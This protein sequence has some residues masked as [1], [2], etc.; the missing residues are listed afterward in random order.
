MAVSSDTVIRFVGDL[1][2]KEA[3]TRFARLRRVPSTY[4]WRCLD[5]LQTIARAR[6]DRLFNDI[7]ERAPVHLGLVPP[8]AK[9]QSSELARFY[10]EV[11]QTPSPHISSRL[12]RGMVASMRTDGPQ[13]FFSNL[14]QEMTNKADSIRPTTAAK[15]R[16]D[17]KREF[18]EHFG[19]STLNTG[20]GTWVYKGES[21]G[22][23]FS[24]LLDY[25][26]RGDQ[27]RYYV[28]LSDAATGLSTRTLSYEV[29][30]GMGFG[31]WDFVTA[32]GQLENVQLLR[33]LIQELVALPDQLMA[34]GSA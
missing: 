31:Q 34:F 4:T 20:G 13:G 30:L 29:L 14:P 9:W 3:A 5:H 22:R 1:I 8:P 19:A 32:D 7:A 11:L 15:I 12:L 18:G 21:L 23:P 33:E 27:L 24:V 10:D 17:V 25:G 6:Q 2:L 26:G 16:K 28:Q